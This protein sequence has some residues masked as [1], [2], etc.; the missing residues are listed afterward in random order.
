[1]GD[2]TVTLPE[3]LYAAFL[4]ALAAARRRVR[5]WPVGRRRREAV[6]DLNDWIQRDI[7]VIRERDI[8]IGPEADPREAAMQFWCQ[9]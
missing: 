2:R 5:R 8:G 1:M 6:A 3:F 7:G 9:Q 4:G